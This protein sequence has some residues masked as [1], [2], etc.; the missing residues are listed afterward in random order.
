MHHS[1]HSQY[2]LSF[3]LLAGVSLSV[4][5]FS[6]SAEPVSFQFNSRL[7]SID[8]T[9]HPD[10]GNSFSE[11]DLLSG[12]LTY[13][14]DT[15]VAFSGGN[16]SFFEFASGSGSS[17]TLSV[18]ELD[19]SFELSSA[20]VFDSDPGPDGEGDSFGVST[21][22]DSVATLGGDSIGFSFFLADNEAEMLGTSTALPS[23][24]DFGLV[25]FGDMVIFGN[26]G[27][28][29]AFA[30]VT[31]FFM[32]MGGDQG[33]VI[34]QNGNL[35]LGTTQP[36]SFTLEVGEQL[37]TNKTVVGESETASFLHAG[38]EHRTDRLDL[39]GDFDDDFFGTPGSG[40]YTLESGTV[41]SDWT[42]VGMRGE[43]QFTQIGGTN[44]VDLLI[45]GNSGSENALNGPTAN[46]V[47]TY[48][49]TGGALDVGLSG[50]LVGASGQGTFNQNG[51][52]VTI[53]NELNNS[54][55]F[56]GL[57]IGDGTSQND[58]DS[59]STPA[60][61]ER[62]GTYN[63][64]DGDL[65]VYGSLVLGGSSDFS[66]QNFGGRGS[67]AQTGGAGFVGQH[68]IV[69]EVGEAASGNGEDVISDG[70]LDVAGDSRVADNSGGGQA[71]KGR[72]LQTGGV[73]T[74]G[75][76]III[77]EGDTGITNSYRVRGGSTTANQVV[78]GLGNEAAGSALLEVGN[79][80]MLRS[81]VFINGNGTL[82][83]ADGSID[84]NVTLQGGTLAPGASPGTMNIMGD[85]I[86]H[87]GLLE[88][89][90]D[91][92]GTQ[93][94]L[95][96]TG[97]LFF[98]KDLMIDI[99]FGFEPTGDVFDLGSFF[100]V[101]NDFSLADGFDFNA[102]LMFSGLMGDPSFTSV[103][104]FGERFALDNGDPVAVSEPGTLALFGIG[105][106]GLLVAVRRRSGAT[107][108]LHLD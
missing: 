32:D 88:L 104:L 63:F 101:G 42:N 96:I 85:L 24:I 80:G 25:D 33:P 45:L 77:G 36:E 46:G 76:N 50:M 71:A 29:F 78:V 4:I 72:F 48:D 19:H 58:P 60:S 7:T 108:A 94:L 31:S 30:E 68:V 62:R 67:F 97:D 22:E 55:R 20:D 54:P 99:L 44:V 73:V 83:G 16:S 61:V 26:G 64:A 49:L 43:G 74:A 100:D 57:K 89:E 70:T 95:A 21:F 86:L 87:D 17:N 35:I 81:D 65:T 93:D 79:D 8:A 98:G 1:H 59:F 56:G 6:A 52:T 39:A 51:G 66:T 3:V 15:P 12:M 90:F 41:I 38:G 27:A 107:R 91:S 28:E 18:N 82:M 105:L 23:D 40:T 75:G 11:N 37:D 10:F 47:G 14:T 102:N 34:D 92:P 5:T 53:G 106:G 9:D 13:N 69:G 2:A 84:G 103:S